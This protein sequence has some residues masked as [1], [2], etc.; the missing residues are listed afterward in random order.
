[1]S[2]VPLYSRTQGRCVAFY[3]QSCSFRTCYRIP[4]SCAARDLSW[5]S[6]FRVQVQR[7][8]FRVEGL[9]SAV[10]GWKVDGSKLSYVSRASLIVGPFAL[11]LS[12]PLYGGL[13]TMRVLVQVQGFI[14]N[15]DTHCVRGG[16]VSSS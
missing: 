2:E 3:S 7:V 5:S 16:G 10:E 4:H 9:E 13:G 15:R 14:A 12:T 6:G 8:G 1:M 11:I